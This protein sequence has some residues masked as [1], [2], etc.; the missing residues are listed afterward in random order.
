MTI[1]E[2]V[3]LVLQAG[4]YAK[5]GE[6]FV[7]DMGSPVKIDTLAR[8]LIRLSGLKPDEDIKIV[9]TGLRPGEKMFEEKLMAEEGLKTTNNKLIHI[10]NPIAFD[11]DKFIT[12]LED[13]MEAAYAG[14]KDIRTKVAAVVKTYSPEV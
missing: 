2:A 5:G 10:G 7:L 1:P 6:I 14:D 12:Q 3:S 8:N 13:L 11:S 4:T 9:Y